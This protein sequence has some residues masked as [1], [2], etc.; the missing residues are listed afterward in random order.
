ME[1]AE[2]LC[3]YE[4]KRNSGGVG[5]LVRDKICEEFS[6]SIVDKSFEGILALELRHNK[7]DFS[8][9]IIVCYLPPEHSSWGMTS[10]D[11]FVNL[12]TVY[13][14]NINADLIL[15]AGDMNART[16]NLKDMISEVDNLPE[17]NNID[18]VKNSQGEEFVEFL[19]DSKL[20][21]L[22]GRFDPIE[23]NYTFLSTRGRSVVDYM[24]TPHDNLEALKEFKVL[25]INDIIEKYKLN[26]LISERSK[27]PDHSILQ[28]QVSFVSY[29]DSSTNETEQGSFLEPDNQTRNVLQKRRYFF[30]NKPEAFMN[31]NM[32]STALQNIIVMFE[33]RIINQENLDKYYDLLCKTLTNEMDKHLKFMDS[34]KRTRKKHKN[35]KPYWCDELSDLWRKMRDSEKRFLKHV[36]TNRSRRELLQNFKN[37]QSLF[38]KRLRQR[39]REYNRNKLLQIEEVCTKNPKEFWNHIKK[40]GPRKKSETPMKVRLDENT[41]SS[42]IDTVLEKWKND[43]SSLYNNR[44]NE[45]I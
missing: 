37:A 41:H 17:L 22:N 6:V 42:D 36:G 45:I 7:S 27:P 25:L 19:R 14:L 31:S 16:G 13:Y 38:D 23:N 3:I 35:S 15:F 10:G 12:C 30:E 43:F 26:H 28:C 2:K 39:E 29:S 5:I 18:T 11:F 21:M 33:N 9:V 8:V 34:T 40:L 32:W 20:C 4:P 44:P 1:T 24:F